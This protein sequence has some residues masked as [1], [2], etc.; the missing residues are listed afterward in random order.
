MELIL[1]SSIQLS[2]DSSY[3]NCWTEKEIQDYNKMKYHTNDTMNGE[4]LE[5]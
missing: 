2:L 3:D 4:L 1:I 5:D